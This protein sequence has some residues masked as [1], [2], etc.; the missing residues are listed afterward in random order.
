MVIKSWHSYAE[1]IPPIPFNQLF[2]TLRHHILKTENIIH[3]LRTRI[4]DADRIFFYIA[5]QQ[6]CLQ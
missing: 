3:F 1:K 2:N 6:F 4:A 5:K